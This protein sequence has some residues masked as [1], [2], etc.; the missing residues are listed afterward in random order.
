MAVQMLYQS[1]LGGSPLPQIFK[2]FDL[3]EYVTREELGEKRRDGQEP[4]GREQERAEY[5][6]RKR[7]AEEAF[8]FAQ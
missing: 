8:E 6:R 4:Q 1:D 5:Q 2:S 7:Q 3:A